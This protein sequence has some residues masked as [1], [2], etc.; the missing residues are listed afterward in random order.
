[1][2]NLPL[3]G[4]KSEE[5]KCING[6]LNSPFASTQ[7]DEKVSTVTAAC[8]KDK[9]SPQRNMSHFLFQALANVN[10]AVK[11]RIC[12]MT[13]QANQV[14]PSATDITGRLFTPLS[15]YRR[16]HLH[17]NADCVSFKHS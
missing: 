10:S 17:N 1:M 13:I 5:A 16:P 4:E 11:P 14:K 8:I 12:G 7:V 15:K 3:N 6:N 2:Y 9:T